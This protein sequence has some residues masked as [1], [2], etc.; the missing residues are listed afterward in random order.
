MFLYSG[1]EYNHPK[2]CSSSS[3]AK[4]LGPSK[5]MIMGPNA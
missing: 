3:G 5:E 1:N 2:N 4:N